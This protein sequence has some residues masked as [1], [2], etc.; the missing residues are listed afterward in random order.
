MSTHLISDCGS[1]YCQRCPEPVKEAKDGRWYITN[2]HLGYNGRQNLKDG[3]ET[4]IKALNAY[5]RFR[6]RR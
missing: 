2:G 5:N 4:K 6:G 1:N 3:Y